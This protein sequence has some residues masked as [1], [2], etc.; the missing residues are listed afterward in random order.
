MQWEWIGLDGDSDLEALLLLSRWEEPAREEGV[1]VS[2]ME[3]GARRVAMD[4]LKK[5]RFCDRGE[6]MG[7]GV[8]YAR[9]LVFVAFGGFPVAC[10]IW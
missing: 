6:T 2:E 5:R 1:T 8:R 4:R 10:L 3:K 7:C 9:T